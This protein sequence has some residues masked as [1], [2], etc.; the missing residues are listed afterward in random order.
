MI[1]VRQVEKSLL[2]D[3]QTE[4][5]LRRLK[6]KR[7]EAARIIRHRSPFIHR[8][9]DGNGVQIIRQSVFRQGKI[10]QNNSRN[11]MENP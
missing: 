1:R 3:C 10:R 4:R 7:D 5:Q 9:L 2:P 8:L 11:T 6:K